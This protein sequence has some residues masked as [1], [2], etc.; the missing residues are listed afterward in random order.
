[1][2]ARGRVSARG[3]APHSCSP[4]MGGPR[5]QGSPPP[6][7]H[8]RSRRRPQR[9]PRETDAAMRRGHQPAPLLFR[10]E[11]ERVCCREE[12]ARW[13]VGTAWREWGDQ[14]KTYLCWSLNLVCHLSSLTWPNACNPHPSQG[15][16]CLD[17]QRSKERARGRPC[18]LGP[19]S[20]GPA[21]IGP[22]TS[23]RWSTGFLCPDPSTHH[24][25]QPF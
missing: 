3:G 12:T 15:V 7:L 24:C 22:S 6:P 4:R 25:M 8:P 14:P 16:C 19:Y 18:F 5:G 17:R 20:T 1:M 10:P 23:R 9:E 11:E 2:V 13:G 21:F